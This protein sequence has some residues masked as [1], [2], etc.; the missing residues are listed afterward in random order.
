MAVQGHLYDDT[1][2]LDGERT[3]RNVDLISNLRR[4]ND[5]LSL[6]VARIGNAAGLLAAELADARRALRLARER[7]RD[8]EAENALLRGGINSDVC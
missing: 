1:D 4:E 8:L 3:E 2:L 6:K 7:A 5:L